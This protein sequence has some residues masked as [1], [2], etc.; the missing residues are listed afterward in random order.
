LKEWEVLG[1]VAVKP[2]IANWKP[3]IVM[4]TV[5]GGENGGES[6]KVGGVDTDKLNEDLFG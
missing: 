6:G 1:A 5:P 2:G 4:G 3:Q